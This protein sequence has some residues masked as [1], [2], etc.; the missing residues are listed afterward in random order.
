MK[1]SA[2]SIRDVADWHNLGAAFRRAAIGK[3]QRDEVRL[4]RADLDGELARLHGEILDGTVEV[5]RM[6]CFRIRDPK[7]RTIHAPC[8]RERVLHHALIAHVGPVLDRALMDDTFAC[9]PGKGALAAV[10]RAQVHARRFPWY[11]KI[12][13]RAYF[14][15]IDHET[16]LALLERRFKD[17]GL[18]HLLRRIIDAHHTE[19]GKGLPIGA[20]TSQNFANYYLSGL[21]RLLLEDSSVRGL[22]RYMDDL[23]WWGD[24]RTAVRAALDKARVFTKARLSLDIK[25]PVQIGRSS[26]GLS[27][28]G[29]RILPGRL[30]L[31]RRRKRRYA[32]FR[33]KWEGAFAAG[34][35]DAQTLQ[36][37][38]DSARAITAHA[39]AA[40]WRREQLHRRPLAKPLADL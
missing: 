4:F 31:S 2:V 29:Y 21:D 3:G 39:D 20:L 35:V 1:R 40:A 22:V 12:D 9:R 25:T 28:C 5:G 10:K 13:I 38:F 17:G 37:G 7:P 32:E 16:L 19:L 33:Q 18:L 34:L 15:S 11:A 36:A 26:N 27:F 30:L 23:V 24:D 8:F 6:R 14:A